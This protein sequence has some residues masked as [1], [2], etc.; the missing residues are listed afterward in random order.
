MKKK[1]ILLLFACMASANFVSAQDTNEFQRIA[2][3]I[4]NA[5]DVGDELEHAPD[6][7]SFYG[8]A[9]LGAGTN[10]HTMPSAYVT[11]L[12][13]DRLLVTSQLAID[14]IKLNTEKDVTTDYQ[15]GADR[16]THSDILTK[17]EKQDFSIRLD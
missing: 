15:T 4:M 12:K 10:G 14:I 11:Y 17:S 9:Y 8:G 13:K 3:R 6:S 1:T 7:A 2:R 5:Y 16:L